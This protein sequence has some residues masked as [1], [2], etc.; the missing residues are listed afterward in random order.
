[1]NKDACCIYRRKRTNESLNDILIDHIKTILS[2]R[3]SSVNNQV[4]LSNIDTQVRFT[5]GKI[6]KYTQELSCLPC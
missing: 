3:E 2:K 4:S 6:C 5:R 1:M